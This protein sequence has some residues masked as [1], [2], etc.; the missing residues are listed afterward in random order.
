MKLAFRVGAIISAFLSL[1][2]DTLQLCLAVLA[3]LTV[4]NMRGAEDTGVCEEWEKEVAALLSA[5]GKYPPSR[6]FAVALSPRHGAG[7]RVN[8]PSDFHTR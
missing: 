4:I 7:R 8:T 1:Q 6:H 5:A 3:I 2:P